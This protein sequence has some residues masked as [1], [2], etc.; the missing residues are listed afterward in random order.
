MTNYVKTSMRIAACLISVAVLTGCVGVFAPIRVPD[1]VIASC[2]RS[3]GFP[4]GTQYNVEEVFR[5]DGLDRRV[6]RSADITADDANKINR[7]IEGQVGSDASV[8]DVGGVPQRVETVRTGNTVTETD[9]YGTPPS[10]AATPTA[11][12]STV[13]RRGQC[14][15]TLSGG[16]GYRCVSQ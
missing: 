3:S 14:R 16:T 8:R 11:G 1:T 15:L 9:T 10:S 2:V 12:Q 7:C 13:S 5:T 6:I 4:D